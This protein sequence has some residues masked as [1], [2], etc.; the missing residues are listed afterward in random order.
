VYKA[1]PK[2]PHATVPYGCPVPTPGADAA[3]REYAL[4]LIE[5]TGISMSACREIALLRELKC[6]I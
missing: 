1:R 2:G 4:K 5:G 6:V 3:I